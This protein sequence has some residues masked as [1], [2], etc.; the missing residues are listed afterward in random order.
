MSWSRLFGLVEVNGPNGEGWPKR[1]AD[2]IE[3]GE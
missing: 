1:Q 3:K 2:R